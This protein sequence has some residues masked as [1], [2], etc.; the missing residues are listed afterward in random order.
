MSLQT[1]L[2]AL[3]TAL[4]ADDKKRHGFNSITT[5]TT[6]TPLTN[7]H[8]VSLTAQASALTIAAPS[9]PPAFVDG[10]SV[11]IRIKDNG[12]ARAISWNAVYRPI[13]VTLPTT[14]VV[15]KTLYVGGKWNAADS[16]V[17]VLAVGQQA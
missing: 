10:Q 4:G 8:Q 14:T 2:A 13:G 11:I 9:G 1:R 17:D 5:Q 7:T 6:L 16:V 12:T 15:G 3:I